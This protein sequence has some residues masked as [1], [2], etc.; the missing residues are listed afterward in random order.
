METI[1]G[2][3]AE[4]VGTFRLEVHDVL[5][6]DLPSAVARSFAQA[7]TGI[8]YLYRPDSGTSLLM[9]HTPPLLR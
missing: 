6:A 4:T 8:A 2:L 3:M 7:G 9:D 5:V 1:G